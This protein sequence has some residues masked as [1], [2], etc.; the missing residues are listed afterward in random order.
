MADILD[1]LEAALAGWYII[2]REIG[3]GRMTRVHIAQD[4][5]HE[6]KVAVR[7][8]LP[9]LAGPLGADRFHRDI[10][11]TANL[12]HPHI[13]PLLHYVEGESLREKL[14]REKQLSVDGALKITCAG[15]RVRRSS[16]HAVAPNRRSP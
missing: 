6:R 9:E 4:L 14:N 12:N 5:M 15:T 11:I 7:V 8:L 10:K 1:R 13:L 3:S 16:H 2:E